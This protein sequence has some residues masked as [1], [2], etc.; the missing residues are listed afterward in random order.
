MK[1][2]KLEQLSYK[3]QHLEIFSESLEPLEFF[4]ATYIHTHMHMYAHTPLLPHYIRAIVNTPFLL[5]LW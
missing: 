5:K 1:Y 4:I 2:K 3:P